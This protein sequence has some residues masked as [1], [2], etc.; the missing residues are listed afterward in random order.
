MPMNI[1]SANI[2]TGASSR[3]AEDEKVSIMKLI[4]YHKDEFRRITDLEYAH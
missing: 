1:N 4:I 2:F 3:M